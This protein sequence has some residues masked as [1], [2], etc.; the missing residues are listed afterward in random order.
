MAHELPFVAVRVRPVEGVW[1]EG[2][3]YFEKTVS[4]EIFSGREGAIFL[5][6]LRRVRVSSNETKPST[7]PNKQKTAITI[8]KYRG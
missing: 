4:P 7:Q 6:A 2:S 8:A 3:T 1:P 5:F